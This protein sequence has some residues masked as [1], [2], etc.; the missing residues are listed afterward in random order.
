VLLLL[1]RALAAWSL[2]VDEHGGHKDL[3]SSGCRS[4]ILYV[5]GRTELYCSSL[6]CLSLFFLSA[7]V[8]WRLSEPF[9]A[10]GQAV[11]MSPEV[12]QVGPRWLKCYTTSRVLMIR[13]SK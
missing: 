8:K 7:P 4:V 6:P 5:H 11:I 2:A 3:Y 9:I 13:S 10:Q 12:R 1:E